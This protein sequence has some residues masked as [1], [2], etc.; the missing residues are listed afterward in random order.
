MLARLSF[1]E[2]SPGKCQN[3]WYIWTSAYKG[4][5]SSHQMRALHL[6]ETHLR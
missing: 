1:E 5:G 6:F 4:F 3:V 2:Y